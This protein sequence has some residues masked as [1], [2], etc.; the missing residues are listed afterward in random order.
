MRKLLS[1]FLL[2]LLITAAG[3]AACVYLIQQAGKGRVYDRAEAIPPRDCGLVLGTSAH[4]GNGDQNPYFRY[5]IAAAAKLYH[6]GKVKHLLLSGDNRTHTYNEPAD[7]KR[8]LVAQQV[9][10]AAITLD[11]AGLRTLDSIDRAE[12]V[13]GLKHFTII[14]QRD[15]DER[16]LLIARHYGIDAIAYAADD[17]DFQY[18]KMA[19]LHEWLAQIKVVLDLFILH[20]E[21][22]H[23]GPR[24]TVN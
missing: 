7:M 8:A 1:L 13:F 4:L 24:V 15:H 23:L 16:A 19:H 18:A 6:L 22:R 3:F 21:P 17:V 5:R 14:S 9:P 11:Y 12:K 10:A 2:L 20:T